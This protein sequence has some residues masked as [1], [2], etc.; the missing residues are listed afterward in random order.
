MRRKNVRIAVILIACFLA[1]L[2]PLAGTPTA[3]ASS[4]LDDLAS[5]AVQNM[6]DLYQDGQHSVNGE[7]GNFSAYDGW[8][9]LKAGVDLDAWVYD[10]VS[11]KASLLGLID[12][13]VSNESTENQSSAK[14]VAEE[15]LAAAGLG[16]AARAEK[17]LGILQARQQ[18]SGDGSFDSNP[19]SDIAALELLGRAGAV[20][21]LD[22]D[23]AV[24]Y[25]LQQQDQ[26]GA[27]TGEWQDVMTTAQGIRALKY[28]QP[29][30]GQRAAEMEDAINKGCEWLQGQQRDDGGIQDD[31][32]WDDPTV[33]TA[34]AICTLVLR[35]IDPAAWVSSQDKSLVDYLQEETLNPDGSFGM[36]NLADNTWV[37]NTCL[38]L[39]WGTVPQLRVVPTEVNIST[40]G[41]ER[42]T[43]EIH[44][45]GQNKKVTAVLWSTADRKIAKIDQ[46]GVLTGVAEGNTVVT[47]VYQELVGSARVWV[48][49]TGGSGD[50]WEEPQ[51][52]TVNMAVLGKNGQLLFGP[53]SVNLSK[54][55]EFGLTAMGALAAT[56]LRWE[57][58]PKY[59]GFIVAIAGE[60]NEGMNGWCYK[61]NGMLPAVGVCDQPVGDDDEIIFWYS[62][63]SQSTGP[64]WS[65]IM[66]GNPGSAGKEPEDQAA[67][68]VVPPEELSVPDQE[69]EVVPAPEVI[70]TLDLGNMVWAREAIAVLI[71]K[72]VITTEVDQKYLQQSITRGEFVVQVVRALGL[73]T[74]ENLSWEFSDIP[75]TDPLAGAVACACY[76][77]LFSGYPD[78]TFQPQAP[79]SR[80]E[81]AV[82]FKR[83]MRP[84]AVGADISSPIKDLEAV[85]AWAREAVEYVVA[86]GLIQGYEDRTFRGEQML[87]RAEAAVILHR[88]LVQTESVL[89]RH[90]QAQ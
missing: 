18:N 44:R 80:N 20:G 73:K 11:F 76:N 1:S 37:L 70:V 81:I 42:L 52:I 46:A 16:E 7:Y 30:A 45:E 24:E 64:N 74:D 85:P 23:K 28:L 90:G 32:G 48:R 33:D 77:G 60:A 26:S 68:E 50:I 41:T 55:S 22:T 88:H 43:A 63:D 56:G 35:G 29:R 2:L 62:V 57:F 34:E 53:G 65:D 25:L 59:E 49:G 79:I 82:V 47:A 61:V 36:G 3:A 67:K 75:S 15:Y 83:M 39:T 89:E 9:L 86:E 84:S 31:A 58:S 78:G 21:E 71:Q 10:G 4:N 72:G 13:T 87:T 6:Y 66:S 12:A 69:G 5:K 8:V 51:T 38:Q 27:W 40:A 17:L 54:D 19:F 14:R